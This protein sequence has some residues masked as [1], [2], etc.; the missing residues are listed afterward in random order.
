MPKYVLIAR[1]GREASSSRMY[2]TTEVNSYRGAPSCYTFINELTNKVKNVG[3]CRVR[4]SRGLGA[5]PA[6]WP[7]KKKPAK[8]LDR[9]PR[10]MY[11]TMLVVPGKKSGEFVQMRGAKRK[12]RGR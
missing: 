1:D 6:W 7:F 9:D 11:Q 12:R 10:R 8:Q 5:L 4:R 3:A 2:S